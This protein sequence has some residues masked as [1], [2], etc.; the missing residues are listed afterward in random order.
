MDGAAVVVVP[1]VLLSLS[2]FLLGSPGLLSLAG[3]SS[4]SLSHDK[5][6][7]RKYWCPRRSLNSAPEVR[8]M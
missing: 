3:P 6:K 7:R 8:Y 4:L 5:S 2:A 1:F